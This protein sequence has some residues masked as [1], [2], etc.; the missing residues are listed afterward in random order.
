M[1]CAPESPLLPSEVATTGAGLVNHDLGEH[2]QIALQ[3]L[4]DPQG[5]LF[6]G[7]ILE[8]RDFIQAAVVQIALDR[9]SGGAD[10]PVIEQ[11]PAGFRDRSFH[12]DIHLEGVPVHAVALV[13]FREGGQPVRGFE[14]EA[15]DEP[16]NHLAIRS[17]LGRSRRFLAAILAQT[18]R[19]TSAIAQVVELG[20]A[21]LG[22]AD[23]LQFGNAR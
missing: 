23:D 4:P 22:A 3:P 20:P 7:W 21:H 13:S 1:Q 19:L 14:G 6:A 12:A 11:I 5:D 2:W 15:L 17:G 8:P 16:D 9:F 18:P 10:R